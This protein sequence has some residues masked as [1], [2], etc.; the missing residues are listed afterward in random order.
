[1]SQG[2]RSRLLLLRELLLSVGPLV[3]LL[4]VAVVLAFWWLNPNPPQRMV[5]ATGP[6]QSAYDAFG[7]R[8]AKA[9]AQ[10]GIELVLLRSEG[11]LHNLELLRS[12]QADLAFVQGGSAPLT[13]E[14]QEALLSMGSLCVEPLW[15]FYRHQAVQ[16]RSASSP[17]KSVEGLAKL[18]GW[19]VDVGT[20]GSGV[21]QLFSGILDAN[22]L[23]D[24]D[25]LLSKL[26]K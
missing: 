16:R 4:L 12:G 17:Q 1:M 6:E 21:P 2:L 24:G 15:I 20:P 25:V 26:A 3:A 7:Q 13:D 9:L 14:D 10:N 5:L 8:Y 19:R 18:K 22:R 23:N 11:S